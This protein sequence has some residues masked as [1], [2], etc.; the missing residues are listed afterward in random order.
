MGA[1]TENLYAELSIWL[2]LLYLENYL[3]LKLLQ[4][5]LEL[6]NLSGSVGILE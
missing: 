4:L 2:E 3:Y 5:Y 6:W 1:L